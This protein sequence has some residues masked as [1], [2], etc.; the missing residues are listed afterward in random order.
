MAQGEVHTTHTHTHTHT[1]TYTHTHAHTVVVQVNGEAIYDS[2]PWKYQNDTEDGA[3]WYTSSK[4]RKFYT[5]LSSFPPSL[6]PSISTYLSH[7]QDG[8]TVYAI[9]FKAPTP[10][11][12]SITN[13]HKTTSITA[14]SL[15]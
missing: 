7:S 9:S 2:M 13:S 14:T 8:K 6:P 12:Y 10:G 4:V 1:H 3:I 11:T 15:I 5:N